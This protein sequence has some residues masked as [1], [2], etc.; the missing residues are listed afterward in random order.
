MKSQVILHVSTKMYQKATVTRTI[1][2]PGAEPIQTVRIDTSILN[3]EADL[4]YTLKIV[5]HEV[6]RQYELFFSLPVEDIDEWLRA[7]YDDPL[8]SMK[9]RDRLYYEHLQQIPWHLA[10]GRCRMAGQ[11]GDQPNSH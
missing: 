6:P 5:E 7:Y 2:G 10:C 8:T 11:L 4:V 9:G 1:D 3:L